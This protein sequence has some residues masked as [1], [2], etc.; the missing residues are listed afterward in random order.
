MRPL[1]NVVGLVV[2]HRQRDVGQLGNHA[3]LEVALQVFLERLVA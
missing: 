3:A 1:F 2:L